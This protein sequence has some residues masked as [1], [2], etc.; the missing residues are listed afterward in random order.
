M[1]KKN[2]RLLEKKLER[3]Y[4]EGYSIQY[5]QKQKKIVQEIRASTKIT[6]QEK[7][8][9]SKLKRHARE[10]IDE[11]DSKGRPVNKF[12]FRHIDNLGVP[13]DVFF[14]YGKK[15][16]GKTVQIREY[17]R[18]LFESDP[19]AEIF[20]IRNTRE[21]LVA[22]E[23]QLN[24]ETGD[25]RRDWPCVM[26]GERLYRRRDDYHRGA[27]L[28]PCGYVAYVSA[29]GLIKWK[30]GEYANIRA[31]IWDEC[32]NESEA[33][34]L[35]RKSF[36]KFVN[37]ISSIVR[38]KKDTK[39]FMFGNLLRNTDGTV[40]NP[41]L[42]AMGI[43]QQTELKL[44]DVPTLDGSDTTKIIYW[45]SMDSYQGIESEKLT[46]IFKNIDITELKTNLPNSYVSKIL[47]DSEWVECTPIIGLLFAY[48][49]KKW[50][51]FYGYFEFSQEEDINFLP[52]RYYSVRI[53]EFDPEVTYGYRLCSNDVT[54]KNNNPGL[55]KHI[56]EEDFIYFLED[57][58]DYSELG[59]IWY[60][61]EESEMLFSEL[62][63]SW[64]IK[65][66]LTYEQRES[67]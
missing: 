44:I 21:E 5:Q 6:K 2:R 1:K 7:Q 17:C 63:R 66:N 36:L 51:L 32:N 19:K 23:A 64:I 59:R 56:S 61:S 13:Y 46:T 58:Y 41:I 24:N 42:R 9:L 26:I 50:C 15:G 22:L 12:R 3:L 49:K 54:F 67:F 10:D 53:Q 45:N 8:L 38:D 65:Y 4:R 47:D 39:I 62:L 16:I 29:S 55:V 60:G 40:S 48:Q 18:K 57:L 34:K 37:F 33:F 20:L 35:D 27:K 25:P 28:K 43:S 52:G 31:I 11:W 14:M 30:G